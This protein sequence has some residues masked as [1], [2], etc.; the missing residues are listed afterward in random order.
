MKM[1]FYAIFD[2]AVNAYMRPMVLQTDGQ[3]VRM[4]TDE[5]VRAEAEI[6]KH[7]E[8]YA[9]FRIGSFDDNTGEILAIEPKCIGRARE[10]AAA[11]RV[12]DSAQLDVVKE[13]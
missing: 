9:L 13:G 12:S 2:K 4:F 10:L 3:A 6:A 7:P 1:N 11:S 8:D 5:A